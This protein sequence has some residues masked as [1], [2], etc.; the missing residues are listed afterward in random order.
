MA[1]VKQLCKFYKVT[2]GAIEL[3]CDGKSALDKA[4]NSFSPISLED[5][6][7]DLPQAIRS[8]RLSRLLKK[9]RI[10]KEV[11][12]QQALTVMGAANLKN[13]SVASFFLACF[14]F[15]PV[16]SRALTFKNY[17]CNLCLTCVTF[18]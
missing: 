9:D 15:F 12:L 5:A 7:H 3:G 8:I 18:R 4:F 11:W 14:I 17:L 16:H 10:Y 6:D 2:S 13:L 1:F